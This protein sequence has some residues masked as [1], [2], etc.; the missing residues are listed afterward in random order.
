MPVRSQTP[1]IRPVAFNGRQF[2]SLGVEVTTWQQ[3]HQVESKVEYQTGE[4]P[5]FYIL[6]LITGG[7][8]SHSIDFQCHH[9]EVGDA[10]WVKPG[11][12]QHWSPNPGMQAELLFISPQ[13]MPLV[14]C[15]EDELEQIALDRWPTHHKLERQQWYTLARQLRLLRREQIQ[16]PAEPLSLL[17]QRSTVLAVLAKLAHV[18]RAEILNPHEPQQRVY[19]QF[20][21]LLEA[22]FA[23]R[24]SVVFYAAQLACSAST[25]N[26]LCRSLTGLSAK[27][28]IDRRVAL[29]AKR[30]LSQQVLS[31]SQIA[32][33]LGFSEPT[34]F[35]KF[36]RRMERLSPKAFR[37]E[38]I[39]GA[40]KQRQ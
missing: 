34:N 32:Y 15:D 36:F 9:L 13:A 39:S 35:V 17:F 2:E 1:V 30:L 26:R 27:Q 20:G 5:Q 3:L 33:Q 18:Y 19:H 7:Q 12:S 4:R 28:T 10:V 25:L 37:Q 23:Q 38:R 29:E 22:N 24:R 6:M 14:Q 21:R 31:V 11:Q 16:A 8:G 40:P